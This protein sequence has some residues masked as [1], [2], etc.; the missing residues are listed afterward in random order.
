MNL[1]LV[2]LRPR[3]VDRSP[4]DRPGRADDGTRPPCV[5]EGLALLCVP[6]RLFLI[7]LPASSAAPSPPYAAY[8]TRVPAGGVEPAGGASSDGGRVRPHAG[9][10]ARDRGLTGL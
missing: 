2:T 10:P 3:T 8:S 9:M 4:S 7:V 1:P 6:A 5:R